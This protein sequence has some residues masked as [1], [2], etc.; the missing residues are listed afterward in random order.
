M[1]ERALRDEVS[2]LNDARRE[3]AQRILQRLLF[4][5]FGELPEW[6]TQKLEAADAKQLE[7]WT[8][9]ILVVDSLDELF[10]H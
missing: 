3:E 5:R 7:A 6:A 2:L 9:E 8:D 4:K 1:R 10:K